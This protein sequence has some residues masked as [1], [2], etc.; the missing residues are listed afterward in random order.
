MQSLR[1]HGLE[2]FVLTILILGIFFRAAYLD[3]KVYWH[4]ETLTS[5][6]VFGRT[7]TEFLENAFQ[8]KIVS[9]EEIL[10]YQHPAP[11]KGLDDTLRALMG[12]AE[13]PPLY[14]LAARFWSYLFGSSVAAMRSL[15]AIISLLT[16]PAMYWLCRE[17]FDSPLVSWLA[18]CLVAVSPIHVLYAQ[19][20]RE[21]S[22]WTV[23]TVLSSAALLHA[24]RQPTKRHW[25]TYAATVALGLYSHL[26]A[27]L[28][29]VAHGLYVFLNA[30][31]RRRQVLVPY[32]WS[33]LAGAIAFLPWLAIIIIN[34]FTIHSTIAGSRES[35][36]FSSLIGKWFLNL[37]RLFLDQEL[38][39]LNIIF[40]LIALFAF[41]FLARN[42]P[43][44]VWSFVFFLAGVTALTLVVPDLVLGGRRSTIARYLIPSYVGIQLAVAHGLATLMVA[45]RA[46]QQQLGKF[47]VCALVS[48]GIIG[49]LFVAPKTVWWTKSVSR[50]GFFLP[51]AEVLNRADRPLVLSDSGAPIGLL[52]LCRYLDPEIPFLL[53]LKTEVPQIPDGYNEVFLLRSPDEFAS[54]IESEQ[55]YNVAPLFE[56]R[57]E[58]ILWQARKLELDQRG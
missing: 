8:G 29:Y 11:D 14:Y 3:R 43:P 51:A 37:N 36:S 24:I 21:Y 5:L 30:E 15:P 39:A 4:D 32:C 47:F 58:I 7:K 26:I 16:L 18:V 50:S 23:A 53:Y 20:A 28:V 33:S 41:Y 55:N 2:L 57:G 6:R 52:G 19:E 31:L 56:H 40:V 42:T 22:L 27:V 44:N 25:G 54:Q 10:T 46:W 48:M 38:G 17:L 45:T 13:H 12:N 1:K 34:I 35:L 9:V 49:S